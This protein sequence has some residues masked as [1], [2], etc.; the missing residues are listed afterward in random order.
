MTLHRRPPEHPITDGLTLSESPT[1]NTDQSPAFEPTAL[2]PLVEEQLIKEVRDIYAG[3][4]MVERKLIDIERPQVKRGQLLSDLQRHHSTAHYGAYEYH[5]YE[6]LSLTERMQLRR[7]IQMQ[8]PKPRTLSP[9]DGNTR[10][11]EIPCQLAEH[12]ANALGDTGAKRNFLREGYAINLG[13]PIA[14]SPS[15]L[16]TVGSGKQVT[17][18]GTTTVPFK[19]RREPTVYNLKFHILPDCIHDVILGKQFLK[20]TETFSKKA[21]YFRRVK[22]RLVKVISQFR[23]LYL[24]ASTSMISGSVNGRA[25]YALADSGSKILAMDEA[26][27]RRIGLKIETGHQHRRKVIFADSSVAET[28]GMAYNVEWRFGHDDCF[29]PPHQLDFHILQSSP[30]D[31]IL[32]D[33]FLF[34]NEVFSRYQHYFIDDD[35]EFEDEDIEAYFFAIDIDKRHEQLQGISTKIRELHS[36]SDS[37]LTANQHSYTLADLQHLEV[38]RRGEEADRISTLSGNERIAAQDAEDQRMAE[39]DHE[40]TI[41]QATGQSRQRI[42]AAAANLQ[43]HSNNAIQPSVAYLLGSKS[44][45]KSKRYFPTLANWLRRRSQGASIN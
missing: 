22:E 36:F 32:S 7:R 24:G 14:S 44:D 16:V 8:S 5:G 34:D 20:H 30:A 9:D 40:F 3:L 23:L 6:N 25:Q 13:L 12:P 11:F 21:N 41:M 31:V 33:T 27:A 42:P 18:V 10:V 15:C 35:E 2:S 45:C 37:N 26:Y 1:P 28:V 4:V 19:F 43:A 17:T 39:W 29:S 38:V